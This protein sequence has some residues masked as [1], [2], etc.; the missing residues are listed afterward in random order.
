M[1]KVSIIVAILI[2]MSVCCYGQESEM[3]K[4]LKGEHELARMSTSSTPYFIVDSGSQDACII[5]TWK[6]NDGTYALS[7]LPSSKIRVAFCETQ[8]VPTIKFRWNT[9]YRDTSVDSLMGN[10]VIYSVVTCKKSDWIIREEENFKKDPKKDSE[11]NLKENLK[12][13]IKEAKSQET[14]EEKKVAEKENTNVPESIQE[15]PKWKYIEKS[16]SSKK[17]KK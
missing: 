11:E 7:Q 15:N 3:G 10:N 5:F 4:I 2:G 8:A 9:L 12:P 6:M 1:N 17:K 13:I 16:F 14:P